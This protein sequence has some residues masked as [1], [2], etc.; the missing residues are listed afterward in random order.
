MFRAIPSREKADG[1]AC[2]TSLFTADDRFLTRRNDQGELSDFGL[3]VIVHWNR[4]SIRV[5]SMDEDHWPKES[6][7]TRR[8]MMNV[9][10][11]QQQRRYSSLM[12]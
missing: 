10:G 7:R 12:G 6:I 5:F 3:E 11:E 2:L 9:S 1:D 8:G 4:R